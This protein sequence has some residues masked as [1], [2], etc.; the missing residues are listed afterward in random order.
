MRDL[1][2]VKP[3]NVVICFDTHTPYLAFRVSRLAAELRRK[4]LDDRV[5][6]H[7]VLIAGKESTYGWDGEAFEAQYGGV[8]VSVLS[9]T[10]RGLGLRGYFKVSTAKTCLRFFFKLLKLRPKVVLVGGYDRPESMLAAF[11]AWLF[12]WRVGV[13]HDSRFNDAESYSKSVVLERLKSYVVRRYHFF[14]CSGQ[15]C[16]D[17]SRFLAG[18]KKPAYFG[19]WNVVDNAGIAAAAADGSGDASIYQHFGIPEGAPF[20]LVAIRFIAKKNAGRVIEAYARLCAAGRGG[21]PRLVICGQGELGEEYR[22]EAERLGVGGQV[23]VVPW[24]EYGQV[25]R[26][27]KLSTAVVLASTHDQWGLIINEALAAGAP[28]LVSDRCGAH[29]LVKNGVNGYTFAPG[30]VG[31]LADLMGRLSRRPE[32]LAE[33]RDGARPSMEGFAIDGFLKVYLDAFA[34]FG[35][36]GR[37]GTGGAGDEARAGHNP[38]THAA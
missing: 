36:I 19:G 33:L 30:D 27:A 31:H 22:A 4:G 29:E 28:V 3:R 12:R 7:V 2:I 24:L 34:R 17:Y 6:L 11:S 21:V 8:P 14:M 10:F 16:V 1:G 20:F 23:S 9:S 37:A 25:P 15:E 32:H 18:R 26:A 5:R 38:S 35:L 13:M